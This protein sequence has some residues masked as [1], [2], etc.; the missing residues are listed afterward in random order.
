MI[1]NKWGE[2]IYESKDLEAAGWDGKL[3][4]KDAVIGNYAYRIQFTTLDGRLIDRSSV[5][6]LAR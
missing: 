3:K 2:L 6:L 1:M 4:G 5:F